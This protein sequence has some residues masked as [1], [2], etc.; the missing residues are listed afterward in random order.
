MVKY[1]LISLG[2]ITAIIA[3]Y[4]IYLIYKDKK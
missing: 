2:V 4:Y 3:G 1:T